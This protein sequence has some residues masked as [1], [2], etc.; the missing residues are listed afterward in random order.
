MISLE[1]DKLLKLIWKIRQ[2]TLNGPIKSLKIVEVL[3][4]IREDYRISLN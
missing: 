3:D 2:Y 1:I 4:L